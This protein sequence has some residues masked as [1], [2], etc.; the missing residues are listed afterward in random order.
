MGGDI[1]T[2][3]PVTLG[4]QQMALASPASQ[5]P[6]SLSRK[7]PHPFTLLFVVVESLSHIRLFSDPVDYPTKSLCPSV[8]G[9]LQARILEWVAMPSSRGSS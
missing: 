6:V 2:L 4:P 8:H 9:F 7:P 1:H 3:T 5:L